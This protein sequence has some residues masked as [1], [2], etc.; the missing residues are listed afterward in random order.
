MTKHFALHL[1]SI[2]AKLQDVTLSYQHL[3]EINAAQKNG[4][5][6]APLI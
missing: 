1:L 2:H 6:V 4:R 5:K 3:L